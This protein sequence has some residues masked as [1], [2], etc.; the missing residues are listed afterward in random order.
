[1]KLNGCAKLFSIHNTIWMKH[2]SGILIGVVLLSGCSRRDEVTA[3]DLAKTLFE[4]KDPDMRGWAARELG[5]TP[6]DAAASVKA[7]TQALQDPHDDVRMAAAYGIADLGT[8]A[9]A[10]VPALKKAE[11]DRAAAVRQAAIYALK[12]IQ[13]KK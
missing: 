8:G 11:K 10:A 7:L 1:M 9:S 4:H 3:A 2:L 13:R 6:K 5:R 12:E